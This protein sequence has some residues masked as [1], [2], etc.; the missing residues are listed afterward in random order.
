MLALEYLFPINRFLK[1]YISPSPFQ[2][3]KSVHTLLAFRNW[4]IHNILVW[5]HILK[6]SPKPEG[7]KLMMIPRGKYWLT[8][9]RP[10]PGQCVLMNTAPFSWLHSPFS[11][12]WWLV[13]ISLCCKLQVCSI[14]S[15]H[16]ISVSWWL[17]KIITRGTKSMNGGV[18]GGRNRGKWLKQKLNTD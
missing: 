4:K 2:W 11:A 6:K 15:I 3:K 5:K 17:T 9:K 16:S 10:S 14:L 13:R 1:T 7:K 8:K 18:T 12:C